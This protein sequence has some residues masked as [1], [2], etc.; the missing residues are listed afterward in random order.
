MKTVL[1]VEDDK[2]I[3]L[4]LGMRLK[5]MGYE[6]HSAADAV[7]AV[8]QARK[9]KPDV[10][11]IDFNL[12]GG[13][14]FMVAERLRSLIQTSATPFVIITASKEEGLREKAKE[15]GASAFLEKPFDATRLADVIESAL[16]CAA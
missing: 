12:P 1:L 16:G 9:A 7:T 4:A 15:L 11:L 8:S 3:T 14:G 5:A 10:I 6:V 13:N 2:E